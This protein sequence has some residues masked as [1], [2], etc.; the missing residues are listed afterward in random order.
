MD[1][2]PK[3]WSIY[4]VWNPREALRIKQTLSPEARNRLSSLGRPLILIVIVVAAYGPALRAGYVWDDDLAVTENP[5]LRSGK[6]LVNIWTAPSKS[7]QGHY[8]PLVYTTFWIQYQLWGTHPFGYHLG[9]V[10][11]HALNAILVWLLL[12][13]LKVPGAW[14]AAALFAL[15]PVQVES[16][17]WVIERKNVLSGFFYFL[18]LLL[19]FRHIDRGGRHRY[20]LALAFLV[21]AMLSKT[22][23]V[24][25][26]VA[27]LLGLWWKGERLGRKQLLGLAPFF[28]FALLLGA[29][30][31]WVYH[32]RYHYS[33]GLSL[34]ER[35]LIAG[36]AV[37]F[38]A[39]KLLWPANLVIVYPRW[40]ID[41][42]SVGQ[43]LFP[44]AAAVALV[45]L[46]LGQERLGKGPLAAF[47][48]FVAALAPTL[49]LFEFAYMDHSYVADHFQY[50]ASVGLLALLAG[51][52][53]RVVEGWPCAFRRSGWA[54]AGAVLLLLG[55]LTWR[56]A[57]TYKDM[58]TLFRYT[59]GRNPHSPVAHYNL[60]FALTRQDRME[61]AIPWYTRAI[62]LKPDYAQAHQNLGVALAFKG[63]IDKAITHYQQV[64][65][66]KPDF[67]DAHVN[68][69]AA[70][71]RKGE[72]SEAVS[73]YTK[74]LDIDSNHIPAHYNLGHAYYAVGQ[75]NKAIDHF[76]QVLKIDSNY[77]DTHYHLANALLIQGRIEEAE[78][79]YREALRLDAR[80]LP[81]HHNLALILEDR[82]DI[83]A[84]IEHYRQALQID[85]KWPQASGRLAW[86]LA[87]CEDETYRDVDE[88]LRLAALACERGPQDPVGWDA[89]AAAYAGTGRF[90]EAVQSARKALQ[91]ARSSRD[92]ALAAQIQSRIAR[93][94]AG[95]PFH[96][97]SP[98][99]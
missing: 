84:A 98:E 1:Y 25:L 12:R 18:S 7:P 65:R 80:S 87:T 38:Y 32:A 46:W 81:A 5:H 28:A 33:A 48:F 20:T 58:E 52:A 30:D 36:R 8:W 69:G 4:G 83:E 95:V 54:G 37:W 15:H 13:E 68:W 41:S 49:G 60:G 92:E 82:G 70:L 44:A 64:L 71:A 51:V 42:R 99:Q 24:S 86:I 57:E 88:A 76:G 75:M 11:L 89:L 66:L 74:A 79:H 34:L 40:E 62:E 35:C 61:E 72:Y 73:Q 26:P 21:C 47:V 31:G 39:A 2:T 22:S 78:H 56:Q 19:F 29:W 85:P 63:D 27:L 6:G 90:E 16:V 94:E 50:L 91:L 23:A 97:T 43:L 67:V 17:A 45:L 77:A 93:Y 10:L 9:N 3:V 14:L 55:L 59:I 53:S 96:A